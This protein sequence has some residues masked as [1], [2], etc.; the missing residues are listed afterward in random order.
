MPALVTAR[1]PFGDERIPRGTEL[2]LS[3][4]P[5]DAARAPYEKEGTMSKQN[6]VV[7]DPGTPGDAGAEGV[8]DRAGEIAQQAQQKLSEAAAQASEQALSQLEARKA[9]A[10]EGLGSVAEALEQTSEQLRNQQQAVVPEY[11]HGA[12]ET[13]R[14]A[15]DYL[16]TNDVRQLVENVREVARRQPELFLGGAFVLGLLTARFLK[17]SGDGRARRR[18]ARA[19]SAPIPASR[20]LA[21][22][23]AKG[24]GRAPKTPGTQ[25]SQI[26]T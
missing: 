23:P 22:A 18:A 15:A 20:A 7:N 16:K 9:Q 17:S 21:K 13:I 12:A 2:A 1:L 10:A 4:P 6:N 26:G 11:L 5:G 24:R 14:G 3:A 8:I 25:P 19:S